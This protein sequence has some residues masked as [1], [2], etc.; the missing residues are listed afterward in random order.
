MLSAAPKMKVIESLKLTVMIFHSSFG[1]SSI[2]M[3]DGLG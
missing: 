3:V 2:V 1:Q